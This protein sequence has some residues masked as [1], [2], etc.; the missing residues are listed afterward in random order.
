M[1]L[2]YKDYMCGLALDTA[3]LFGIKWSFQL[4]YFT[5]HFGPINLFIGN[6]DKDL[7]ILLDSLEQ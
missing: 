2:V 4:K 6:V 3:F 5:I 7:K 1:C